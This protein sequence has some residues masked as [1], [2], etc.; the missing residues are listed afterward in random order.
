MV[1]K[2]GPRNSLQSALKFWFKIN[3]GQSYS[4]YMKVL[5]SG[6]PPCSAK[7][8]C[9]THRSDRCVTQLDWSVTQIDWSV[10]QLYILLY[11][12]PRG[13][14]E[15]CNLYALAFYEYLSF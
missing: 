2:D 15:C 11:S 8:V 5:P 4:L 7:C 3:Y 13:N 14:H 1:Y 9:H 10:T 12:W 6:Y